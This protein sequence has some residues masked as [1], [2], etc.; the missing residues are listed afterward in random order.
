[1]KAVVLVGGFGTRLRPLTYTRPKQML[2]ICGKP[3]I[4]WVVAG[5]AMHGV[6]E[7]C[8]SLGYKPEPFMEAFP[9]GYCAGAKLHYAVEPE[10]LD[11]AGAIAFAARVAGFDKGG[12]AFIAVNG[13]VLTDLDVTA[14]VAFH[15]ARTAEATIALTEVE[16]PSRFGVVPTDDFGRVLGFIEKPS[17]ESA[18]T[19]WI[20]AGTYVL[21]PS[22][23]DRIP[24]GEKVSIERATFP[25]IV[26]GGRMFAIKSNAYWLD[27]GKPAEY[28]QAQV[29]LLSGLRG[30]TPVD[31]IIGNARVPATAIIEL[32][33]IDDGCVIGQHCTI[34]NSVLLP[35]CTVGA[36]V[37]IIDSIVGEGVTIGD[38]AEI[39]NGSVIGD[40]ESIAAG[41]HL[42]G[43]KQPDPD[44]T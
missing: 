44:A 23:L 19:R 22:V 33:V 26:A 41:A 30:E 5:L 15:K 2:P 10:P 4:E 39:L 18:P 1:M 34:V 36:Y 21:E 7:I 9:S 12:R 20:N 37:R 32:S 31:G 28:I 13:D 38:R 6:T 16:D 17:R 43:V 27:T 29:D 42:D 3:M 35:G 40:G 14:L 25:A 24:V 8:L 11:T